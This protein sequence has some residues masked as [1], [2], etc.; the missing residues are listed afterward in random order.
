MSECSP[1]P[2]SVM[3][4]PFPRDMAS[5][6]DDEE[7]I[8]ALESRLRDLMATAPEQEIVAARDWA[9]LEV[10]P[11][12]AAELL[13]RLKP[14]DRAG[15]LELL[16]RIEWGERLSRPAEGS[17]AT[18][19][20]RRARDDVPNDREFLRC[21]S[22]SLRDEPRDLGEWRIAARSDWSLATRA[23][24][25]DRGALRLVA[26][27]DDVPE[28]NADDDRFDASVRH[29]V[30][31]VTGL[32]PR[33]RLL[34]TGAGRGARVAAQ[35]ACRVDAMRVVLFE[36]SPHLAGG[37]DWTL[38]TGPPTW[39][40]CSPRFRGPVECQHYL[41]E[42]RAPARWTLACVGGSLRRVL[43]LASFSP[44][45]RLLQF[46]RELARL[47]RA[48]ADL[49]LVGNLLVS[50][51]LGESDDGLS[52]RLDRIATALEEDTRGGKCQLRRVSR[53]PSAWDYLRDLVWDHLRAELVLFHPANAG[54]HTLGSPTAVQARRLRTRTC[55]AFR[56]TLDSSDDSD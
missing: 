26:C 22:E 34:M 48:A 5:R 25:F 41:V 24:A 29:V 55:L 16:E 8:S 33:R 54:L 20:A 30:A 35:V 46:S 40:L 4:S 13:A 47:L 28:D 39:R 11:S 27:V 10:L 9:S 32:E 23:V 49:A 42:A 52:A 45:A 50:G 53:W 38:Y 56:A 19:E 51:G 43:A 37:P 14:T 17:T 7:R 21:T 31:F 6:P 18:R 12:D 44:I 1:E 2:G 36:C 3:E 15:F